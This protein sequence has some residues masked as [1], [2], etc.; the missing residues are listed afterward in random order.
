M[1][2]VLLSF[3]L[4]TIGLVVAVSAQ[5]AATADIHD[6]NGKWIGLAIFTQA[7]STVDVSIKINGLTSGLH[8]VHIHETGKCD[9]PD[10][11]SA[12]GHFNP[13]H[14]QHGLQNTAGPH[15]GDLPNL[16]V[17]EQGNAAYEDPTN[18]VT[19]MD[20]QTSLF[21]ADGS[22]IVIHAS[23]DD[24]MT[25]PSGNSGA[26]IACGVIERV[27]DHTKDTSTSKNNP[28]TPGGTQGFSLSPMTIILGLLALVL[29]LVIVLNV[30]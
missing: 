10:F 11:K 22:S 23:A 19:L 4:I 26:R 25:D 12:G 21:D 29:L 6:A 13:A 24:E 1:V 15:A 7:G 18:R 2:R 9:G 8:G 30:L 28:S 3:L 16:Q 5:E 17:D 27:V 20:G 14:A